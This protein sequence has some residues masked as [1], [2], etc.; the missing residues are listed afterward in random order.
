MKKHLTLSD[1]EIFIYLLISFEINPLLISING[2]SVVV[3]FLWDFYIF[4]FHDFVVLQ[5]DISQK[6]VYRFPEAKDTWSPKLGRIL[7]IF[8]SFTTIGL[9]KNEIINELL[10]N[11]HK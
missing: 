11:I 2:P 4:G 3:H 1:G 8:Y 5:E 6:N 10:K 7:V 9:H